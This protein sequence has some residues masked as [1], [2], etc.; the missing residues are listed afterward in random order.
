MDFTLQAWWVKDGHKTSNPD[1][2]TYAGVFLIDSDLISLT[3][4]ALNS[5][6]VVSADIKNAYLQYPLSENH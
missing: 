3:Y 2:S 6:D 5:I 4:S 1:Q